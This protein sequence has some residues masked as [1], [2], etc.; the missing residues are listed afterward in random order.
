MRNY[1]T[2][3]PQAAARIVALALVADGHVSLVEIDTLQRHDI[4]H[5]LGLTPEAFR[6]VL[7]DL[8]S[9]LLVQSPMAWS[10]PSQ[11]DPHLIGNLVDDIDDP[12]LCDQLIHLC[13]TVIEA[14]RHVA[15]GEALMLS[16]AFV[17]WH[18]RLA[19]QGSS[20]QTPRAS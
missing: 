16:T 11:I 10:D 13:R 7:H 3:S 1:P 4:A 2:N 20:R 12:D 17:H 18:R 8:C 6:E 9:D 19:P 15:D 14:D 5:R